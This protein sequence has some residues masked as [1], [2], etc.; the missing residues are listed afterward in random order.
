MPKPL[1][2]TE[3]L[4]Q[5]LLVALGS[6][7]YIDVAFGAC[8]VPRDR[9]Y[10]WARRARA[11]EGQLQKGQ[12]ITTSEQRLVDF[13]AKAHEVMAAA[14]L[15]DWIAIGVAGR[16]QW[17]ARAWRLERRNPE[18]YALRTKTE[19]TGKDGA[20][21]VDLSKLTDE[22]L[23]RLQAGDITVLSTLGAASSGSNGVAGPAAP[24]GGEP[25]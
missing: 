25:S 22:Q 12:K 1:L 23:R 17:Q 11:A 8:G 21:L 14:E 13:M 15:R 4:E 19:L 18:R 5:R 24:E 20:P 9:Y 3:E 10:D 6:G 2:L 7:A 16:R